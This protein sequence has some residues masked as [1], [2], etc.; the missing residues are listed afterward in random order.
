MENLTNKSEDQSLLSG[1]SY[2]RRVLL[3]AGWILP[4]IA[5]TPL[6]NTAS[7]MSSVDCDSLLAKRDMHRKNGDKSAYNNIQAK[8][9]ANGCPC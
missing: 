2:N 9:D 6:I 3:K 7:A 8:L 1:K 5:V 4:V